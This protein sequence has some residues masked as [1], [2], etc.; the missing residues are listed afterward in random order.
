MEENLHEEHNVTD[1]SLHL[2]KSQA[3][4]IPK[5]NIVLQNNVKYVNE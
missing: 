4:T 1:D 2:N 5:K 3:Q